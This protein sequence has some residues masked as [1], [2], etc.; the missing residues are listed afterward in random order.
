M[1]DGRTRLAI[2]LVVIMVGTYFWITQSRKKERMKP[3]PYV[4]AS[5]H[6]DAGDW[7]NALEVYRKAIKEAPTHKKAP[8][9]KGRIGVCLRELGREEEAVKVFKEFLVQYP[10][11]PLVEEAGPTIAVYEKSRKGKLLPVPDGDM[12]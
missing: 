12:E 7:Q 2:F 5:V 10:E 6:F 9:A 1:H 8:T 4:Q 3:G 11:H